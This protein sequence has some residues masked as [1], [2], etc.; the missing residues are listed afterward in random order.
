M[1][2]SLRLR[3]RR[4]RSW[5]VVHRGLR[6]RCRLAP[7]RTTK[8]RC[9]CTV[10][11]NL[12]CWCAMARRWIRLRKVDRQNRR[13]SGCRSMGRQLT[14]RCCRRDCRLVRWNRFRRGSRCWRRS[15]SRRPMVCRCRRIASRV[16]VRFG[17]CCGR[18]RNQR[19]CWAGWLNR[20]CRIAMRWNQI[21]RMLNQIRRWLI[22]IRWCSHFRCQRTTRSD[23]WLKLTNSVI[24]SRFHRVVN[25]CDRFGP[26]PSFRAARCFRNHWWIG[27]LI[28]W[29]IR[30]LM[31][32]VNGC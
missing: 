28:G 22:R 17:Y 4:L 23:S 24:R 14:G 10:R 19:T 2:S 9:C 25:R 29:W 27:Y 5:R 12:R 18:R 15:R 11:L 20:S 6:N 31:Q 3:R 16:M 26:M 21:H 13:R 8:P 30:M 1:R 7:N 32:S